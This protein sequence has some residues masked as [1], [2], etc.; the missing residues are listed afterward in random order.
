MAEEKRRRETNRKLDF[1]I[2]EP[3][4]IAVTRETNLEKGQAKA[5]S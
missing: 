3:E 5:T 4:R 1:M 2:N